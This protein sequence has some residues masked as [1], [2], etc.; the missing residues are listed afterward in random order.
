[1]SG[2]LDSSFI[3]KN[4]YDRGKNINSY[5]VVLN[6]KKYDERKWSQKVS[7]KY[8]TNHIEIEIDTHLQHSTSIL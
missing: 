8:N 6:D 7:N 4:M 3:V 2:G 1:M 5:S